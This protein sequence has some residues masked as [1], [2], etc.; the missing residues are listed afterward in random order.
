MLR[1]HNAMYLKRLGDQARQNYERLRELEQLRDEMVH[2]I[3]HDMRSPLMGLAGNLELL[4]QRPA[5]GLDPEATQMLAEARIVADS[6]TEM[7]SSMLDMSRLEAGQ[8]P[9]VKSFHDVRDIVRRAVTSLSGLAKLSGAAVAVEPAGE[10]LIAFCDAGLIERVVA[11]LLSNAIHCLPGSGSVRIAAARAE[12]G[13]RVAVTDTGP[14]IPRE[15]H[16]KIFEKFAQVGNEGFRKLHSSGIG[17]T[18]CRLAVEA[19]G[20][21]IG[22]ESEE[23]K[24]STFWFTIPA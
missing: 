11:N 5:A 4:Q 22:I 2:M 15:L 7:I 19:H 17:L 8:M 14:G 12:G 9:V 6:L 23:G 16:G 24:G 10:P 1:V 18:F 21:K 13:V 20:G 3:V